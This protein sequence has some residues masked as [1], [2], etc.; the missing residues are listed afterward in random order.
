MWVLDNKCYV[1]SYTYISPPTFQIKRYTIAYKKHMV[2]KQHILYTFMLLK[3]GYIFVN[4]VRFGESEEI[5]DLYLQMWNLNHWFLI[6]F[7][8]LFCC[9]FF[10][11]NSNLADIV[12]F[13]IF[14]Y[15]I[16]LLTFLHCFASTM[17]LNVLFYQLHFYALRTEILQLV[18]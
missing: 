12:A 15:V 14:C 3:Y 16:L 13:V 1:T 4:I 5:I 9:S 18:L 11:L 6:R 8:L 2:K 7:S 17:A 10:L